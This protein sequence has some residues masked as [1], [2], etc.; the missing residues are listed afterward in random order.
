MGFN[1]NY[2][3]SR[4]FL[5]KCDL[6]IHTLKDLQQVVGFVQK[7]LTNKDFNNCKFRNL[8]MLDVSHHTHRVFRQFVHA[9][10]PYRY[11]L[12]YRRIGY[13][14]QYKA[15]RHTCN[16]NKFQDQATIRQRANRRR[17][18]YCC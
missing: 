4:L 18:L 12:G 10:I 2:K 15:L 9:F 7:Q 13:F 3:D 1:E 6:E 14:P 5:E 17:L 16:L 8:Q 11:D